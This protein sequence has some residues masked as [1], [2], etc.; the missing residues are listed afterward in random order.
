MHT[1]LADLHF[2]NQS[3]IPVLL[4][5][6]TPKA[7]LRQGTRFRAEFLLAPP[8]E[9]NLFGGKGPEELFV[10]FTDGLFP[11]VALE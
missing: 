8:K 7:E 4:S 2:G 3:Q 10:E 5:S 11:S 1:F 9:W 6:E